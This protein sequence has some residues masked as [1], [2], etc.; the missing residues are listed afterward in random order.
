MCGM[1]YSVRLDEEAQ[2]KIVA[3]RL[4]R[5]G[6]QAI[7][8]RMDELSDMPSRFLLR[9]ESAEHILQPTSSIAIPGRLLGIASSPC[10]FGMASMTR[11]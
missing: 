6:M 10:R 2:A 11:P 4:P 8:R 5:E 1:S 7:F 3:W 9:V